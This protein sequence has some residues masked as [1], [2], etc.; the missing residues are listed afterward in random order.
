MADA[1]INEPFVS[2]KSLVLVCITFPRQSS[3]TELSWMIALERVCQNA[4]ALPWALF[5]LIQFRSRQRV[6]PFVIHSRDPLLWKIRFVVL[7]HFPYC[8]Q[9]WL[10]NRIAVMRR[11][12]VIDVFYSVC[13]DSP[14]YLAEM[15]QTCSLQSGLAKQACRESSR[16]SPDN[17]EIFSYRFLSPGNLSTFASSSSVLQGVHDET[18]VTTCSIQ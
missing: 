18:Q 14:H 17:A 10:E 3:G 16:W 11:T 6:H 5:R 4:N 7:S 1:A 8:N 12:N 9:T 2:K 13:T 15:D